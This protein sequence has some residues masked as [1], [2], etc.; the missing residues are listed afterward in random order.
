[1]AS[2]VTVQEECGFQVI[3]DRGN[4]F[5]SRVLVPVPEALVLTGLPT[6]LISPLFLPAK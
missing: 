3:M 2:R 5:D 4:Y 1:M 6:S